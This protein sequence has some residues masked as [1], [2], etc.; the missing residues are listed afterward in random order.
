MLQIHGA[1]PQ[2]GVEITGID[3]NT[4]EEAIWNKIYQAWL[5][6]NV[7]VVHDQDLTIPHFIAAGER[8]GR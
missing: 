8:F 4:M 3:V 1:G 6:L 7:M 2:T 5:D